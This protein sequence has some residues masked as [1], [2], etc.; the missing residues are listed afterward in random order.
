MDAFSEE[1]KDAEAVTRQRYKDE[2][3]PMLTAGNVGEVIASSAEGNPLAAVEIAKRDLIY[4]S[5]SATLATI[6]S[7]WSLYL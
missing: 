6:A 5:L 2:N 1:F 3:I 4:V 7:V